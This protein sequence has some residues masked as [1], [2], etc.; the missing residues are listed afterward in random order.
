MATV[1]NYQYTHYN[2][3]AFN[4][5]ATHTWTFGPWPWRQKGVVATALP[6]SL[7]TADRALTVSE[8]RLRTTPAQPAGDEW[9]EIDVRNVGRDPIVI[10]YISLIEIGP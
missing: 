4:P 9:V 5:G 7:S 1:N 10:Y 3:T 6:F 8:V 2:G